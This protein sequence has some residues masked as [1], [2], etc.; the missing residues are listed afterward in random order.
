MNGNQQRGR[1]FLLDRRLFFT[2][3]V[4]LGLILFPIVTLLVVSV[5]T[6]G[7]VAVGLFQSHLEAGTAFVIIL[8]AIVGLATSAIVVWKSGDIFRKALDLMRSKLPEPVHSCI[9][10]GILGSLLFGGAMVAGILLLGHTRPIGWDFN[11]VLPSMGLGFAVFLIGGLP[12][13]LW[14]KSRRSSSAQ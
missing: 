7:L 9:E 3:R 8:G 11:R 6:E 5:V 4:V 10:F 14:R 1:E 12:V 2:V 13:G